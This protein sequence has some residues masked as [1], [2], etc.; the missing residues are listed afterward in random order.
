[1]VTLIDLY[2]FGETPH[3]DHPLCLDDYAFGVEEIIKD[4][5][6]PILIGH[7]F[8]GRVALRIAARD[9]I[10]RGLVLIDSAGM[11]PRRSLNYYRKIFAYKIAKLFGK[12]PRNAGSADYAAL[13]GPMRRTFVNI[14][15]ESNVPDAR[16]I[17]VPTILLWGEKDRDTPLYMCR[18]MHALIQSSEM[19]VISDAGHFSYLERPDY[20]YCVIRAFCGGI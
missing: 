20:A 10:V 11:P 15:N 18:K 4:C 19:I 8:G 16:V 2:G 7:S 5:E 6:D 3:P 17:T 14:V 1:M 12:T 9:R 13:T